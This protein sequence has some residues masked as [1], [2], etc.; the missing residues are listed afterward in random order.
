MKGSKV[1]DTS[2]DWNKWTT[3]IKYHNINRDKD[4]ISFIDTP[5]MNDKLGDNEYLNLIRKEKK[6]RN[7]K[8]ELSVF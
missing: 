2:S 8:V 6:R 3:K 1:A 7:L 4:T 5:G